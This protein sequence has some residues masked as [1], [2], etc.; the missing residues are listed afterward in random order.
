MSGEAKIKKS[1]KIPKLDRDRFA[2][3]KAKFPAM[4]L[5]RWCRM[6]DTSVGR[7]SAPSE[8]VSERSLQ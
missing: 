2:I 1:V 5:G 7:D 6:A 3:Y 4:A 8:M